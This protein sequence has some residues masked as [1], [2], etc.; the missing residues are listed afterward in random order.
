MAYSKYYKSRKVSGLGQRL[1]DY[2]ASSVVN[3]IKRFSKQGDAV[4]EIGPGEGRVAD[5]LRAASYKYCAYEAS[6]DLAMD[7]KNK[8][9]E[10]R[11]SYAPPLL[12]PDSSQQVVVATHVLEHMPNHTSARM[13]FSEAH[14]VLSQ[15]G[16]L[17]IISPDFND[18]GK[19][20]FDVDY[21]HSFITTPNRLS[22]LAKDSGLVV[23]KRKFLYGALPFFPGIFFNLIVRSLFLLL[24][25]VKENSLFE[26]RGLFKLEYMFSR[27]IYMVF[28]KP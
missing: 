5:Q 22:Q 26:Y 14:R 1:N 19:L 13:F 23:A 16:I 6:P 4:L 8:G 7:L 20:F 11:E 28:R 27:A 18:M 17:F 10:V 12:E 25:I 2:F 21:S 3:E 15:G 9:I 24:R